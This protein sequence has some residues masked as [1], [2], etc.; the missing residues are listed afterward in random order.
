MININPW[1]LKVRKN[2]QY[3]PSHR[4]GSLLDTD[5]L[6]SSI[7]TAIK[8][9]FDMFIKIVQIKPQTN[10]LLGANY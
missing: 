1:Q 10:Y 3:Q 4:A 8:I 9:A 2:D 6:L 7:E 5:K